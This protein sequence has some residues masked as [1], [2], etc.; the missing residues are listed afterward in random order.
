[1]N[2]KFMWKL[3]W[4]MLNT[5]KVKM[6]QSRSTKTK[7]RYENTYNK[8]IASRVI[9]NTLSSQ[10]FS[11]KTSNDQHVRL[12]SE[13]LINIHGWRNVFPDIKDFRFKTDFLTV[14][15][16]E[17]FQEVEITWQVWRFFS[18]KEK[19]YQPK[20]IELKYSCYQRKTF[21]SAKRT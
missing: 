19:K 15:T 13:V 7:I 8:Y 12:M 10:V 14:N 16:N 3:S 20:T 21:W 5:Q 9:Q 4:K 17:I 1:M 2:L 11:P 18:N 6:C